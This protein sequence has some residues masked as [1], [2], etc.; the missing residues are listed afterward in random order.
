MYLVFSIY[1]MKK[2]LGNIGHD[3]HFG[4]A[5]AGFAI[6]LALRTSIFQ[7][8][9]FIVIAMALPIIALFVMIK[10]GRI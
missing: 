8:D 4:G 2:Q 9:T 5:V 10:T 3:A 7:T 1:G 6:T